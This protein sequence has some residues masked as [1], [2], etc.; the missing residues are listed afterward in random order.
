MY[1]KLSCGQRLK[2]LS[3]I[4]YQKIADSVKHFEALKYTRIEAPWWVSQEISAI[5]KPKDAH[6]DYFI[7][8]N[9]K[10]LV[11]SGEQ[12]LL[13]TANKGRLPKGRWL[14]VTPCFR[15]ESIGVLNKKCFIKTELMITDVVTETARDLMISDAMEFFKKQ[16]PNPDLLDL[17]CIDNYGEIS[18]D[19]TY[20][21]IEL[22]SYGIR[23]CEFLDWIY[24]T[25][26]AEPRLSRAISISA[27]KRNV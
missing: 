23:S 5:T 1:P 25:G 3:V 14:T 21:S 16:V 4:D 13:Y 12:S 6:P 11:A 10:S 24:G 22:G 18:Y 7:P 15:N 8:E 27:R 9:R 17:I 20:D 2:G 26:C 19:I